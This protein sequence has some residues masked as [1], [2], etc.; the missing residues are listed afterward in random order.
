MREKLVYAFIHKILISY[1]YIFVLLSF[2][3]FQSSNEDSFQYYCSFG[4]LKINE[5]NI[6]EI[7]DAFLNNLIKININEITD[8]SLLILFEEE[9]QIFIFKQSRCTYQFLY[10]ELEDEYLNNKLHLFAIEGK[11]E[12]NPN[13]IKLVIQTKKEFQIFLFHNEKRIYNIS[14]YE[15]DF[16]IRTNIYHYF[17]NKFYYYKEFELFKNQNINIFNDKEKIF[18][19]ICY[20]FETYNINNSPELRKNLYYYKNDN[21]TYPLLSTNSNC[22][23]I[24]SI[25]SFENESFIL[26]YKCKKNLNISPKDIQIKGVSILNDEDIKNYRG[27]N[28]LKDQKNILKC[29][30]DAFKTKNIKNNIG[31]YISLFLIVIEVISII[32]LFIK[33]YEI[34]PEEGSN[35]EAP[36]KKKSLK[37]ALKEKK[38]KKKKNI[39]NEEIISEENRKRKK[40]KKKKQL[41]N[42]DNEEDYNENNNKNLKECTNKKISEEEKENN[43]NHEYLKSKKKKKKGK[44][45]KIKKEKDKFENY[46]MNISF[47]NKSDKDSDFKYR[48]EEIDIKNKTISKF[49][50]AY[51]KFQNDTANKLKEKINIRRLVIFTNL[52][53]GLQKLENYNNYDKLKIEN[54][55]DNGFFIQED[56]SNMTNLKFNNNNLFSHAKEN[57]KKEEQNEKDKLNKLGII[58]GLEDNTFI[59]N[60]M[61]DYLSF[62]EAIY[63]DKRNYFHNFCHIM[64]LK[65]DFINI[66]LL[67]YSFVPFTIRLIKFFFFFHLMFYLETLCIGQKYYFDKFYSKEFQEFIT[68]NYLYDNILN[69]STY[70]YN[71]DLIAKIFKYNKYIEINK[72]NKLH[73]LYIF[74]RAFPRVLIPAAISLISYIFT[75]ILSPRRKIIK[76]ILN[77]QYNPNDK[78]F[79]I[80]KV[81]EKYEKIYLFVSIL[82]LLIMI[83]FLYSLVNYFFVFEESKYD[84]TQ[85]FLLSGL[86]RF[87]FDIILWTIIIGLRYCSIKLHYRGFY[88][89]LK[90]LYEMN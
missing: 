86:I 60:I 67:N 31:F 69:N 21:L 45:K 19:D 66:F 82:V 35:L 27:P 20:K 73:F 38:D 54:K 53:S 51:N 72:F 64:K 56:D 33:K 48:Y 39:N 65:N 61:R 71:N 36:P 23:I 63:F 43:D 25:I 59:N 5:S 81:T 74:K 10:D 3:N 88:N 49:P 12:L 7:T 22:Y 26:E 32:I 55:K 17:K 77:T 34:K 84:I 37:E 89:L 16:I 52:G 30:K 2:V 40:R 8:N 29:Y 85:S 44:K 58:I 78:F 4:K 75:S 87:V 57:T 80:R 1:F 79:R 90:K 68:D 41:N 28:S 24:R 6:N 14:D 42:S 50:N 13:I 62:E 11:I 47:E 18:N 46:L 9:F 76:I 83:F 15:S 70:E